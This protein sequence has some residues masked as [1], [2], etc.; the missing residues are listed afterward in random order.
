MDDKDLSFVIECKS[1]QCHDWMAF[2]SWYSIRKRMPDSKVSIHVSLDRPFF[3]WANKVGVRLSRVLPEGFVIPPTVAAAR[4]F[5]GSLGISSSKSDDQ[6]CLVDYSQGC[7]NFVVDEWIHKTDIPF[8]RAL[9]RFGTQNMTVN[10]MAILALWESCHN[11][12][13]SVGGL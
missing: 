4:D 11:I 2:A 7:G 6:T 8:E 1:N 10:E 5:D 13:Q 3:R 12:Y 9:R